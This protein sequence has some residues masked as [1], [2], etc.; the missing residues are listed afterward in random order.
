MLLGNE[1]CRIATACPT[2]SSILKDTAAAAPWIAELKEAIL[3]RSTSCVLQVL[4]EPIIF[5]AAAHHILSAL[6]HQ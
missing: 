2:V 3:S 4:E 5:R 1:V 6:A